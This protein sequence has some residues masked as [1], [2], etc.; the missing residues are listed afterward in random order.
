MSLLLLLAGGLTAY[1]TWLL[2]R[3]VIAQRDAAES[4]RRDLVAA[5]SHDLRTP[6]TS[7]RLLSEAIEDE[8]VD[9]DTRARYSSRCRFTSARSPR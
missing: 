4:A 2:S 3:D 6:L 9:R 8:L 7:L 5:V 1:A